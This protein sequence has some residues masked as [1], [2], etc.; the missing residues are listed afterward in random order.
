M[1]LRD[2]DSHLLQ[3]GRSFDEHE[4]ETSFDMPLDMTVEQ[5]DAG[6]IGF[7]PDHCVPISVYED[8]VSAH[9]GVWSVGLV[10]GGDGGWW[11]VIG[12]PGRAGDDLELVGVQMEG[13]GAPVVI[14]DEQVDDVAHLQ[15]VGVCV[16]A[17]DEGVVD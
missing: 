10:V 2:L 3:L 11:A 8:S 7:K 17:V 5:R 15:D 4:C 9:R 1:P 14:G 12:T 16:V 6:V 13:V